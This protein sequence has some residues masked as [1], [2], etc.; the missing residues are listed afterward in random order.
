MAV[1]Q[2]LPSDFCIQRRVKNS[3]RL[4]Y[5]LGCSK[6]K[7]HGKTSVATESFAITWKETRIECNVADR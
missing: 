1:S 6:S 7:F 4:A 2:G 3:G 5:R